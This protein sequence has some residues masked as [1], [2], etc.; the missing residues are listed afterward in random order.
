VTEDSGIA[1]DARLLDGLTAIA[2]RAAAAILAIAPSAL[3]P[4]DKPDRTPITAADEASE[5]VILE[6]L[7]RFLPGLP[8]VSE[9]TAAR[10]DP[11][12]LGSRFVLVDPLDGT[13]ELLAGRD[14]FT[15]NIAL[16]S[17]G[18]PVAGVVAAPARGLL[19]RGIVG[20]RAERLVLTPNAGSLVAREARAIHTRTRHRTGHNRTEHDRAGH[21]SGLVALASRS[22]L[23]PA[24]EAYLAALKPAERIACGSALKFCLLAEGTAD[25]YVR[26]A[27]TSEWDVGA[28]H[29]VVAAAGGDVT[30]PDGRP[31]LYGKTGFRVP[32]FIAWGDRAA[33]P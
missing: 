1:P 23:D 7:G 11:E 14:E 3:A 29:A 22:H 20:G 13:R 17:S 32:A 10:A 12:S 26:L 28:G 16:I 5:A 19:W 30:T 25:L 9:E 33:R 21:N 8:V 31:L 4:R 6:G 27:P 2:A 18:H 24:T 15:I